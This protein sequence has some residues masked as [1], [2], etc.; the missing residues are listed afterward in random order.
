MAES[1]KSDIKYLFGLD[2]KVTLLTDGRHIVE[3]NGHVH[4]HSLT[5]QEIRA[6]KVL[7]IVDNTVNELAS[8][9]PPKTVK[10]IITD[11]LEG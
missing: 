5:N 6:N 3:R 9:L 4:N 1:M 2:C 8:F 7:E 10:A 11:R